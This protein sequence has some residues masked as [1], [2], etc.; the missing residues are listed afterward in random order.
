[1]LVYM[2]QHEGFCHVWLLHACM[3]GK[4]H[5]PAVQ[6]FQC[7]HQSTAAVGRD[8]Q[9]LVTWSF[10][11][12]SNCRSSL[13]HSCIVLLRHVSAIGGVFGPARLSLTCPCCHG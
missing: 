6:S 7:V 2:E 8:P 10:R 3:H 11:S 13:Q 4:V 1:M 12:S 5:G 9:L